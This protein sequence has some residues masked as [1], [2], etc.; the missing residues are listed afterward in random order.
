MACLR[1]IRYALGYALRRPH[2]SSDTV[3]IEGVTITWVACPC[4]VEQS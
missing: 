4:C 2:F 3:H 1:D